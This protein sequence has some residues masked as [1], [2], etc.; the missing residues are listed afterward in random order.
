MTLT[1]YFEIKTI[2]EDEFVLVIN[3]PH[4]LLTVKDRYDERLPNLRDILKEKYGDMFVVH[5]L[6]FGTAGVMVFAKNAHSH[7]KLNEQFESQQ[8]KKEY[9][10][11]VEG[12]GFK[13]VTVMLPISAK[14]S[15]GK[16][17]INFKSGKNAVT[18]FYTISEKNG[19]SLVKAIPFTGRT[20]QIR[21]HLKALKYPLAKD[22]LYNKKSEDKRLTLMCSLLSFKHPKTGVELTFSTKLTDFMKSSFRL[23]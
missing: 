17:K 14:N 1:Q 3:K 16:Y 20:H 4:G 7:R 13:P 15:H 11:V 8:V 18:S 2:Y 5:R 6:D 23:N 21:V 10:G 12:C 19:F 9:L 22:F